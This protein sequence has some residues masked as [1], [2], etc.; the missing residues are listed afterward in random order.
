MWFAQRMFES[1]TIRRLDETGGLDFGLLAESLLFYERVT[2]I[3]NA[4]QLTSLVRVCG[5]ETLRELLDMS[6]L[7]LTFLENGAG[8][9]TL[10]TGTANEVHDF[11]LFDTAR[12]HLQNCLPELLRELIH[13]PGKARRVAERFKRSIVLRLST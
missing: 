1:L 7:S 10:N 6:V 11:I 5:H 12:L 3:V 8:V 9:R 2:L 4:G 13:R